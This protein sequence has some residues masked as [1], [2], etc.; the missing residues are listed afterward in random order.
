[1][2][3]AL[4]SLFW[5][6]LRKIGEGIFT[7][8][9]LA[10]HIAE[11]TCGE[12]EASSDHPRL[13]ALSGHVSDWIASCER[14]EEESKEDPWG[15]MSTWKWS[16]MLQAAIEEEDD[17]AVAGWSVRLLGRL[18]S[19]HRT[20]HDRPFGTLPK[21]TEIAAVHEVHLGSWLDRT[22]SRAFEPLKAFIE[23]FVLEWIIYRHLRVATRKLATRGVSTFKLRPELGSLLPLVETPSVPTFTNPRLRQ[24]HRILGD[25]HYLTIDAE[26]TRISPDGANLIVG[27]Q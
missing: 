6:V 13:P 24:L 1:M 18:T 3:Y 21:V 7:P 27:A 5:V 26:G 11:M 12:I 14:A 19:D 20:F 16:D 2:N 10:H 9:Q 25:L 8:R 4:E 17:T 23:E 15:H 22:M